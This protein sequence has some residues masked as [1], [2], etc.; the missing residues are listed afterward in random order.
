[1]CCKWN[2]SLLQTTRYLINSQRLAKRRIVITRARRKTT[3]GQLNWRWS[4]LIDEC[5]HPTK[6][7]VSAL[8][9]G[10]LARY[11]I[12]R[13]AHTPGMPGT[14]SPP[15]QI[16]DPDVYHGKCVTHVQWCMPGSLTS[17]FLWSQWR[18]K[19]SRHSRRMRNPYLYVSFKRLVPYPYPVPVVFHWQS[20]GNPVCLE[21]R[22]QCT[23]ECHWRMNSW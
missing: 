2:I 1:M 17:G 7:Y 9:N 6:Q 4:Y 16:S 8:A 19:R 20:S 10:A 21:R 14:F 15:P 11:V 5:F 23:P 12:L 3:T 18:G 22:P 13:V